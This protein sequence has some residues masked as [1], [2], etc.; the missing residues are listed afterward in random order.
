VGEDEGGVRGMSDCLF[1]KI[2]AGEIPSGVVAQDDEFL[3]FRDINPQAPTHVLAIPRHHIA[4]LNDADDAALIGRLLL[5][6]RDVA[7]A[8]GL[9]DDGW[10]LVVNTNAGAGQTVFH[11]HAHILGG[12][13]MRWPPG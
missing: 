13:A 4:T 3:A 8:E 11:I 1:C 10:R 2:A 12:R 9:A 6:A 5:F 7:R